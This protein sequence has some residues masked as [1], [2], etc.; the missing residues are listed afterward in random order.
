MY[1]T[2]KNNE[3]IISDYD[4]LISRFVRQIILL[5]KGFENSNVIAFDFEE[6]KVINLIEFLQRNNINY[7]VD[8]FLDVFLKKHFNKIED[9]RHHA[10]QALEIKNNLNGASKGYVDFINVI[11][12]KMVRS[13][14]EHQLKAAYHMAFSLNSCNFSVPG[15]GKTTIVYAAYAYLKTLG[16]IDKLF[17]VGPLSSTMAWKNEYYECFQ[18]I[19]DFI[20]LSELS[21]PEKTKYFRKYK[22]IQS[23]INFIN[24]EAFNNIKKP[25]YEFLEK[26]RVMVVLDEAHKIKNPNAKRSR[27]IMSFADMAVSRIILTGTPIPNGY[28]DLYNLFEFVWP[29]KDIIG[30]NP[31]QLKKISESYK[32][33]DDVKRLMNNIDPFYIR[34]TKEVLNLPKPIFNEPIYVGMGKIQRKIYDFIADDFL[35]SDYFGIDFDLQMELKKA[36]LIRLMQSL[37]NPAALCKS[38]NESEFE[39][40]ELID[41]ICNYENIEIPTK[42]INVLNLVQ[43]IISNEGKVIIWTQFVYNLIGLKQF[44]VSNNISTELLYGEIQNEERENII[45]QFHTDNDLKVIIANPAAVAESISLHKAC[46]HAIYMDMSFNAAHYMQS[47]DRIHRVGLKPSDETNYYFL[48]C[49][50]SIDE[51]IYQRVLE[52]EEVMLNIIEGKTVPLFSKDFESDLSDADIQIVYDYLSKERIK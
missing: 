42:Y 40:S 33:Q 32:Y 30:F 16:K 5:T 47:K 52:K 7:S 4:S 28:V 27:S 17:I 12:D 35:K 25:L 8:S 50:N 2:S 26:N 38:I 36:K 1:L 6:K 44:L 46:H 9:F 21:Q 18:E 48:L 15:S 39:G 51:V 43:D 22:D 31:N 13:L 29:G 11:K 20:N 3:I 45:N 49:S 10:S 24:Y 19:P 41:L 23:E 14:Y 34:I 37:T